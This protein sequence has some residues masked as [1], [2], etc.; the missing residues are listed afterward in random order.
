MYES[1]LDDKNSWYEYNVLIFWVRRRARERERE[2][3]GSDDTRQ[4]PI[5]LSNI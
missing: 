5:Y 1:Y 3:L 2:R 4:P